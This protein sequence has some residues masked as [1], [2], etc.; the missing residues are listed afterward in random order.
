MPVEPLL[1][2]S[3]PA[4]RARTAITIFGGLNLA[5]GL[6]VLRTR[7][8][9]AVIGIG[10]LGVEALAAIIHR[11]DFREWAGQAVEARRALQGL[12]LREG[13][14]EMMQAM[15]ATVFPAVLAIGAIWLLVVA[16]RF[17]GRSRVTPHA[18]DG[19]AST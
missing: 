3:A 6:L 12:P 19:M 7:L 16:M 14:V 9:G 17:K 15:T 4:W 10:V 1:G 8:I 13:E 11:D 2:L 5:A 18:A